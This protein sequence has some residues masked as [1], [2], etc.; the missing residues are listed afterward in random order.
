MN[1]IN[2]GINII[3]DTIIKNELNKYVNGSSQ[4]LNRTS[5]TSYFSNEIIMEN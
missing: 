3:R 4:S 1:N 2:V 5:R